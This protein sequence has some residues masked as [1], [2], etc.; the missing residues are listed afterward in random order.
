MKRNWLCY[1]IYF[2]ACINYKSILKALCL[3]D[4]SLSLYFNIIIKCRFSLSFQNLILEEWFD[5][6]FCFLFR[7]TASPNPHSDKSCINVEFD[8]G[9][10]GRIPL[11]HIRML[12]RDYPVVCEYIHLQ[13]WF[14]I[15]L[16]ILKDTM[17]I[18]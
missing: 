16:F 1:F 8:D 12:P 5:G 18:S 17:Y 9:D 11:D 10:S 13:L 3:N 2:Y 7:F 6:Y 14:F 4:L 15:Y